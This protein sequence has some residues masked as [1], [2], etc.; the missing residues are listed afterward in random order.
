MVDRRKYAARTV[1]PVDQSRREIE[2]TLERYGATAFAYGATPGR[3]M[4]EFVADERRVRFVVILPTTDKRGADQETRRL[5]RALVLSI[6]AK[7]EVVE[8]GI[9]T[10]E[11]EFL[12]HVVLPDGRTVGQA[13]LPEVARAYETGTFTGGMLAL[14]PGE[15]SG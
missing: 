1:V 8:S 11:E 7:L 13:T 6:K 12:A 9:S 15:T 2:K 14:T 5:W 10:F 3:A 4:V